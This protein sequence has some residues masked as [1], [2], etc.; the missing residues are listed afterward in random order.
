MWSQAALAAEAAEEALRFSMI[1]P[2]RFATY[3]MNSF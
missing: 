2:P 1:A 3:V